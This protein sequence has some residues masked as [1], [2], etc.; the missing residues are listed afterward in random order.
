MV[1]STD[2]NES[3][4]LRGAILLF[5]NFGFPGVL[6]KQARRQAGSPFARSRSRPCWSEPAVGP[7]MLVHCRNGS[8]GSV[9]QGYPVALPGS[10]SI[11]RRK[12][13]VSRTSDV[14]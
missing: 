9:R 8:D 14:T 7:A 13:S 11:T 6:D 10:A 4:D 1:S 12:S 3:L 2:P 5:A